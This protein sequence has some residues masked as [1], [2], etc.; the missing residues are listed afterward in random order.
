[1]VF[2]GSPWDI[3]TRW[4]RILRFAL[5]LPST[6]AVA[7]SVREE[8]EKDKEREEKTIKE[9]KV[10]RWTIEKIRAVTRAKR[11]YWRTLGSRKCEEKQTLTTDRMII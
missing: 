4:T 8:G 3:V 10:K 5:I 6:R 7:W 1:M 11:K 9:N 2:S